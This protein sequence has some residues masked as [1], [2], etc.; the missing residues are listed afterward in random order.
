MRKILVVILFAV[1]G[2][3]AEWEGFLEGHSYPLNVGY[4]SLGRIEANVGDIRFGILAFHLLRVDTRVFY[5]DG[6]YDKVPVSLGA[7]IVTIPT[8]GFCILSVN[9]HIPDILG[10]I[11][12]VPA[13]LAAGGL[14]VDIFDF[15]PLT[16]SVFE[17]H[18]FEWWLYK[19]NDKWRMDEVGWGEELGLDVLFPYVSIDVGAQFEITNK[20][21]GIGWFVRLNMF[22]F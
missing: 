2:A 20:R 3:A 1:V 13:Y 8:V 7:P 19:K 12:L 4:S 5:D 18:V 16:L 15:K 22:E 17:S 10:V 21:K 11:A 14:Y 9:T 6:E